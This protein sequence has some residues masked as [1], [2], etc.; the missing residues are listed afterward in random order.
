LGDL[1]TALD[2]KK[3]LDKA[4]KMDGQ[5]KY[6]DVLDYQVWLKAKKPTESGGRLL[7]QHT[8]ELMD[9]GRTRFMG[10]L[11]GKGGGI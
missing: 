10:M 4:G 9:E 2:Q 3:S 8:S 7:G 11:K 1:A 5:S 6:K